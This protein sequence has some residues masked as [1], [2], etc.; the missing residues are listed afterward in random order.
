MP[1][2][3]ITIASNALVRIGDDPIQ[4]WDETEGGT[5][6]EAFYDRHKKCLIMEH[7]W[8]F[9]TKYTQL[10]LESFTPPSEL[11]YIYAHK[12]PVSNLRLWSLYPLGMDYNIWGKIIYSNTKEIY[13]VHSWEITEDLMSEKFKITLEYLIAKSISISVTE[14]STTYQIMDAEYQKSLREAKHIDSTTKP[15]QSIIHQPFIEAHN[16]GF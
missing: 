4:N 5:V 16:G 12:L 7:P 11:G 14:N 3:N 13:A 9:A 8:T 1:S 6:T 15:V 10:T 2:E